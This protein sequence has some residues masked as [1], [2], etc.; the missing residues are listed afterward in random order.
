MEHVTVQDQANMGKPAFSVGDAVVYR[1]EG[2]C[3]IVDIRKENFGAHGEGEN[4]YILSPR[5]DANSSIYVPVN[6]ETLTALMRPILSKE[7]IVAMIAELQNE[8][9]TWLPDSRS[10]NTMFRE[11]LSVGDR[12]SVI[13]LAL[14]VHERLAAIIEAGKKPGSTETGALARAC[15]LLRD[16]FS[17]AIPLHSDEELLA[18]LCGEREI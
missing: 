17:V 3:D 4:Y 11:I 6:N 1:A 7:E 12:R 10:R 13:V 8:R 14:T 18:V 5:N 15:K 16:E 2:V 9:L